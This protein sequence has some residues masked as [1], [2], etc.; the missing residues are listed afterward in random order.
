MLVGTGGVVRAFVRH[1]TLPIVALCAI[2]FLSPSSRAQEYTIGKI[3]VSDVWALASDGKE[4][5]LFM[6]IRNYG[7]HDQLLEFELEGVTGAP[8][9]RVDGQLRVRDSIQVP[10]N[11]EVTELKPGSQYLIALELTKPLKEGT[12]IPIKLDFWYARYRQIQVPVRAAAP[13]SSR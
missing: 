4:S 10:G 7:R 9:E 8:Y 1:A 6:T 13:E 2:G 11:G 12:Q 3:V 5:A